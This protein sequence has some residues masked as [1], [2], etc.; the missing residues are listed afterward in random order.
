MSSFLWYFNK[1]MRNG[2]N[3]IF[4][5]ME[6]LKKVKQMLS[7]SQRVVLMPLYKS[8]AD[9][10]ILTMVH[11]LQGIQQGFTFG[12]YEDTPRI[13]IFDSWLRSAGYVFSKRSE[14]QSVVS[15]YVNSSLLKELIEN[16]PLTT[17]F[18]NGQRFRSG[19][20]AKKQSASMS[21]RWLLDA[22]Q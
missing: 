19:K 6:S 12:C 4:V 18:V 16:Q 10:F 15:N 5:E 22:L 13:K 3:G 14:D 21:V 2:F 7:N 8:Y 11:Y 20:L 1:V 9:F 17:L